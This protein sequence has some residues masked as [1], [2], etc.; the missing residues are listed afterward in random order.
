MR[1]GE[2]L[3]LQVLLYVTHAISLTLNAYYTFVCSIHIIWI[4]LRLRYAVWMPLN[5]N[6]TSSLHD[7]GLNSYRLL[8][9]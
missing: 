6:T 9:I 7:S 2:D 4:K 3:A 8:S 5:A 1:N